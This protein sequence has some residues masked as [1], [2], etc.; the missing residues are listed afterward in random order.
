M[1]NAT[2][3]EKPWRGWIAIFAVCSVTVLLCMPFLRNIAWL[4]DEGVLLDGADR[5]LR[6]E[7]IYSDFFEFLPPGG[8]LLVEGWFRVAGSSFVAERILAILTITGIACFTYLCCLQSS[9]HVLI[10]AA[11]ALAW[12]IWSQLVWS[13]QISHH[14][15]TTLF[16]M[17]SAWAAL[18]RGRAGLASNSMPFLSGLA[19]GAAAMIT[20]TRGAL[21]AIA[22]SIAFMG[23][24]A[25]QVFLSFVAGCAVLPILLLLFIES[26][27]SLVA[28]FADVIVFPATQYSSI[29]S[30]PFA[31]GGP[32][33]N[34]LKYTY[35]ITAF[36]MALVFVLRWRSVSRDQILWT[37]TA[38]AL[39]GVLGAFPRPDL[40]HIAFSLPLSLPLST[41]CLA[42]LV[43][44]ASREL[45]Y[46]VAGLV[47]LFYLPDI[48]NF[49]WD[50][51]HALQTKLTHT[52]R[53][54]VALREDGAADLVDQLNSDSASTFFYP[55][56]PML[57]YL[58]AKEQAAK[59]DVFVPH[60]TTAEQYRETCAEITAGASV[61]VLN[62]LWDNEDFLRKVFPSM[63][64]RE[65]QS[66]KGFDEA[67]RKEFTPAWEGGQFQILHRISKI[68]E[69]TC[70]T[71]R[72]ETGF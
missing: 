30:V 8:F 15:F 20:P 40:V 69:D 50:A 33:S 41:Y 56:M 19:A 6:G 53:G 71:L 31:A 17:I 10:S 38:L 2:I 68:P 72:G 35:P 21:A 47:P 26:Q 22:A 23:S 18:R 39:A 25:R 58:T 3:D 46:L 67:I 62:T 28:A 61:I 12:V 51:K 9:K 36:V 13:L 52:P 44:R 5:M 65:D 34:S 32:I 1:I 11:A 48:F 42:I 27:G 57:P 54:D 14:W 63:T 7:R 43:N 4:G 59:Y 64:A 55:Y 37:S 49:Y 24:G 45:I 16:S 29:Q 66:K 70:S 60:Y